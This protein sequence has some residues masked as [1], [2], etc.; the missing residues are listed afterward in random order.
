MAALTPDVKL[1]IVTQLAC[2]ETPAQVR[3]AVRERFG[4]DLTPQQL[5]PYDPTTVTGQRLSKKLAE[6]FFQTRERFKTEVA[7]IPIASQAYRLRM[8]DRLARGAAE[9]NNAPLVATLLEQAA[10][11]VGGAFTNRRELTGKDGKPIKT[12]SIGAV[13]SSVDPVAAAR[14]YQDFASGE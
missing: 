8:L 6:V 13:V 2:F 12:E 4:L 3:A 10:K 14:M 11:E 5:Q 1:F 9:K 7:D